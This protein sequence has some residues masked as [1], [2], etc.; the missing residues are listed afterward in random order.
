MTI[1]MVPFTFLQNSIIHGKRKL[2]EKNTVCSYMLNR[3][4]E[5][6]ED[7]LPSCIYNTYLAGANLWVLPNDYAIATGQNPPSS[8]TAPQVS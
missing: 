8:I 6:F 1:N 7:Y 5:R 3:C 4:D 2:I